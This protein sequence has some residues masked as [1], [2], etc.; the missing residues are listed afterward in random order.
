[1]RSKE[2]RHSLSLDGKVVRESL[3][4]A[5]GSYGRRGEDGI[6][7]FFSFHGIVVDGGI[8]KKRAGKVPLLDIGLVAVTRCC[9][10]PYYGKATVG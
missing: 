6:D 3:K 1:M 8:T 10:S 2:H 7:E 4:A 9:E 5:K